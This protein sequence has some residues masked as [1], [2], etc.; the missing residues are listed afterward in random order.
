M[1][2]SYL[3]SLSEDLVINFHSYLRLFRPWLTVHIVTA[4]TV[5]HYAT[6][7]VV[8]SPWLPVCLFCFILVRQAKIR[9]Q[10]LDNSKG[11]EPSWRHVV[12]QRKGVLQCDSFLR[13]GCYQ[14]LK[15]PVPGNGR[16]GASSAAT[17]GNPCA[18]QAHFLPFSLTPCPVS[19]Y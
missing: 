8:L 2:P 9:D 17:P 16:C 18:L 14:S 3:F 5:L 15:K 13:H 7:T 4:V 11:T 10:L 1:R 6:E 19:G 12:M